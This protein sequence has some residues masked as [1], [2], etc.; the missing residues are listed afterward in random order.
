MRITLC[1]GFGSTAKGLTTR[2][3]PPIL[4]FFSKALCFAFNYAQQKQLRQICHC[5]SLHNNLQNR[6]EPEQL[7]HKLGLN[8]QMKTRKQT[9]KMDHGF[10]PCA[11]PPDGLE[12]G[13]LLFLSSEKRTGCQ[14]LSLLTQQQSLGEAPS[15]IRQAGMFPIAFRSGK[16]HP[17]R[18]EFGIITTN[19][20]N[21]FLCLHLTRC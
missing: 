20:W 19:S 4:S 7:L 2:N 3:G 6:S 13:C 16:V 21:F 5:C 1:A 15:A 11:S 14:L 9:N 12:E 18:A 17:T 8:A 10:A